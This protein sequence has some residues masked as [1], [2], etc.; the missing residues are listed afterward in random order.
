MTKTIQNT[1]FVQ[2][3]HEVVSSVEDG[4]TLDYETSNAPEST[5]SYKVTLVEKPFVEQPVDTL[6]NMTVEVKVLDIPEVQK[7]IQDISDAVQSLSDS[8]TATTNTTIVL[9]ETK[10]NDTQPSKPQA[11]RP[12]RGARK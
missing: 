8:Q 6:K 4:Y 12:P 7:T 9:D 1:N 5:P 10:S 11:G 2:F 3:M